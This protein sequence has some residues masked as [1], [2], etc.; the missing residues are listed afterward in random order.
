[1]PLGGELT[2]QRGD[3]FMLEDQDGA[4]EHLHVVL[5]APNSDGEVVTVSISTR[6]PKSES[7]VCI[8]PGEHPFITRESVC[9]YRFAAI[10]V[11]ASIQSAIDNGRARLRER[12]SPELIKKLSSGLLDSDF[13]SRGV[14]AFYQSVAAPQL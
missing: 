5:T 9:L 11:C 8:Q 12:A 4:A 10:R 6:R 3:T 1:M 7:L 14:R 2:V 13:T